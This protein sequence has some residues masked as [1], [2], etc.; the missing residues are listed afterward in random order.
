MQEHFMRLAHHRSA[1]SSTI[2]PEQF[3]EV[4]QLCGLDS[5]QEKLVK[6]LFGVFDR[7]GNGTIDFR[8]FMTG[9]STLMRGT[10][11]ERL[12]CMVAAPSTPR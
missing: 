4:M 12:Q 5:Q 9:L 10:L 6:Q 3:M 1:N 8:E 11:A 2:G 7:N